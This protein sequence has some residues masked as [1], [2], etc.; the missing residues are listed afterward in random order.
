MNCP[1]PL[2]VN[3]GLGRPLLGKMLGEVWTVE[4]CQAKNGKKRERERNGKGTRSFLS[5]S[6]IFG[7]PFFPVSGQNHEKRVKKEAERPKDGWKDVER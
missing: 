7:H 3:S 1:L 5:R 6:S 2:N 4:M